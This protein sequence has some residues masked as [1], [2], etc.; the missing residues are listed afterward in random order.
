MTLINIIY[1]Y[2]LQEEG[3]LECIDAEVSCIY[4]FVLAFLVPV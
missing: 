2:M 1:I 4:G 3:M